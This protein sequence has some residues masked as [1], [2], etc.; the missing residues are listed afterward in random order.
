MRRFANG[1]SYGPFCEQFLI[2]K[3]GAASV[4]SFDNSDYEQATHN[5]SERAPD[6]FF[7][8][9]SSANGC[10]GTLIFLVD[11]GEQNFWYEV[12]EPKSGRWA[13]MTSP[14]ALCVYVRTRKTGTVSH[15]QVQQSQYIYEW[16]H[17]HEQRG[18]R[19]DAIKSK[20][21][22]TFQGGPLFPAARFLNRVVKN[23][24]TTL[25]NNSS[26]TKRLLESLIR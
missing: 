19:L 14:R 17:G 25:R 7:S 20:I 5:R 3:F 1:T 24:D 13:D 21:K 4:E 22:E 10:S 16:Q 6:L 23:P 8:L 11:V 9:Y 26:L 2:D 18:G 12:T 15:D